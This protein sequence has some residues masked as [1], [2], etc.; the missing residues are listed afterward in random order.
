LDISI[1]AMA[2]AP[3]IAAL[4]APLLWQRLGGHSA[5][6]LALVPAAIF[7]FL[8][9]LIP[10]VAAGQTLHAA[11]PWA[12]SYGLDLSFAVDGLSLMFALTISGIGACIILYSGAY[13]RGHPHQGRFLAFMLGF[14]GAM[15]G[16]VLADGLV[17]LY[18]FWEL[19]AVFS[20]LL[21]GFDHTRQA[22]RRAALQALV[23]TNAGGLCLLFG[24]LLLRQ[25]TGT[26]NLSAMAGQADS[27][28][29]SGA[30]LP[31]C[32]LIF[33]A[34]FT[35]S[36]QV[37]F[38]FWLPNAME[39]P[40]PV[41][42]YLHSAT[43]VQAGIYLLARLSPLLSAAPFWAPTLLIFG[44]ITML[45]GAIGAL[46]QTDLK[47]MLAQ[48]TIASLGLLVLLL[49]LGGEI[50]A[51]AVIAYFLAHALYKAGFFLIAG[52]IDH[53]TGSRDVTV[54]R[55]LRDKMAVTFAAAIFA[56]VSMFGLPP[57]IG[58]LAKESIYAALGPFGLASALIS[59][60]LVLGNGALGG[61]ALALVTKPFLG[62]P[63]TT[64]KPPHEGT[65]AML[66][67]P[68]LLG[69]AGIAA[70]LM[71]PWLTPQ[72]VAPA[73]SAIAGT[74]TH[75]HLGFA[76]D[77]HEPAIW[78][79]LATW[80][81]SA[82]VY[83]QIE[84]LRLVLRRTELALRVSSDRS[85]DTAMSGLLWL[86][87]S[88]ARRWQ[89]GSLRFYLAVVFLALAAATTFPLL[90]FGG[91]PAMPEFPTLL[92][93]EWATIALLVIGL[94]LVVAARTLLFGI[95]ALGIQGLAIALI[96]L[97][98]GAPDLA[99]TQFMVETLSVVIFA[100]I[101]TRL[102]LGRH[103][104][105]GRSDAI[106]D[107]LLALLC[108]GGIS[109]V[110]LAVLSRRLDPRLSAFFEA[111]APTLAHGRN[112]VNVILVDFRGLDTFGEISV[113]MTAGIAIAALIATRRAAAP[114]VPTDPTKHTLRQPRKAAALKR[115]ALP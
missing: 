105:R 17:P 65:F 95:V 75:P 7:T 35:K 33:G 3:F 19:T 21:I 82:L 83:W 115:E 56:G 61:I 86:A 11:I 15:L 59:F 50:G 39:A 6:L 94:V 1:E 87:D 91:L 71:L 51:V 92:P 97:Q 55:G 96:Y 66:F 52:I 43:M 45:W 30:L 23:I 16:I 32:C 10:D 81:V 40:T 8:A 58:Y 109:A 74:N 42:A 68:V 101:M 29:H 103:P 5:W 77:L 27:V 2:V 106:R 67:G 63:A 34:A 85:F 26:W 14:M 41:S 69:L 18:V 107:C 38:H 64:P 48:T 113:V 76:I 112:I 100:L 62:A 108:G 72:I 99:F 79:S 22:A 114:P 53:E 25:V 44:G 49:G 88:F 9:T 20:Y 89:N 98:F 110:L 104:A 13:L 102:R 60:I 80:A 24:A 12:P 57:A 46:R 37:P 47:Q 36:A 111:N 28:A 54:L 31:I 90:A 93:L 78:L 84:P 4:L 70:A 73:A